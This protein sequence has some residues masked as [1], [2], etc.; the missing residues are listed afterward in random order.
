MRRLQGCLAH[1]AF[2]KI[3]LTMLAV[4]ALMVFGSG[5]RAHAQTF[6]LLHQFTG[7]PDGAVPMT[8]LTPDAAGNFYGATT[9]GA[10][11]NCAG[12]CGTVFKLSRRNGAWVLTT[13]YSFQGFLNG[14][15]PTA[16]VI[17]G[18]DG[19]LY[20]TASSTGQCD[21]CGLVFQ[22]SPPLTPCGSFTCPW[23]LTILHK[24]RRDGVDGFNPNGGDLV[25][26]RSGNIYGTTY[27]GGASAKG[28]VYELT[29]TGG[30]WTETILHNFTG[31][32]G[33]QPVAGVV[34]DSAGNLYGTT[35]NG[36][37]AADGIIF[38]LSPSGAGWTERVLHTFT[39]VSPDGSH[40][41]AGLTP[42]GAGSFYGTTGF[43]G[44]NPC[45]AGT[46]N[47]GC[48][49]VFHGFG[50]TVYSFSRRH[51]INEPGGPWS[52]VTPDAEGNL[53]GTTYSNSANGYGAVFMLSA[54]QFGYTSL[55]EFNN[56][57][58]AYPIG[59]VFRDSNGNLF[60]TTSGGGDHLRGVVW[61]ITP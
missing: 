15:Q 12:G 56:G 61:E 46:G 21:R 44:T 33:A 50:S 35:I 4:C 34:F 55:H 60:G 20:G 9:G 8:G 1:P 31:P 58:G 19:A 59:S 51:I 3:P 41:Y 53:Y 57:D 25:F 45:F 39:D 14:S 11:N 7:G 10:V 28:V 27:D 54:G 32:D 2:R 5:P 42:D 13:L 43:G 40:P 24:F 30:T 16:R 49:T 18:P 6:T 37:S 52:P 26:D 29:H 23:N 47:L 38:E 17:F 48:G 36:G 22:L